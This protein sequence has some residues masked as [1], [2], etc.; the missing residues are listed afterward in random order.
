MKKALNFLTEYS[1][2]LIIGALIALIWAN[3]NYESYTI[4]KFS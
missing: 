1:L 2:L 3:I 4:R